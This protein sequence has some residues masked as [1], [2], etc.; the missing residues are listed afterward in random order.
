MST[1]TKILLVEDDAD[2]GNVLCQ[3]LKMNQYEV[4]LC[5]NGKEGL[6][7]VLSG[8][9]DV[10][11]LDVMLPGV[12]GFTLAEHIKKHDINTPFLFLTARSMKAD[13]LKGLKMGAD[14]YITKPFEPEELL[15]RIQNLL[16][17]TGNQIRATYT[18]GN[19]EF[20]YNRYRLI[21]GEKE[22]N[23]TEREADLLKLL[24][25]NK[26][27]VVKR[28]DI[29]QAVWGE[30]DFFMGR[31]MDVFI[32]RLRKYLSADN[33]ISIQSVRGVGIMLEIKTNKQDTAK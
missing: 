14:D 13:V 2:L 7:A 9:Y 10:F 27:S 31:S 28:S 17:R 32:T 23:L 21:C 25:D 26:N 20:D 19:Y 22:R 8:Q 15:L 6:T 4:D 5:R 1:K 3:Y 29:L 30:D 18:I 24:L 33:R 16:K 12:D 11:V